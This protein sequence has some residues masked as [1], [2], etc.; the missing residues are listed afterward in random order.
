MAFYLRPFDAVRFAVDTPAASS[1]AGNPMNDAV[2]N[3]LKKQTRLQAN[4]RASQAGVGAGVFVFMV[5][6]VLFFALPNPYTLSA[7]FIVP[8]IIGIWIKRWRLNALTR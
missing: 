2:L 4:W 3:E 5:L 7:P 8:I 6:V 1:L